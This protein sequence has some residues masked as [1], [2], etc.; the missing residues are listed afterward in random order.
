[1]SETRQVGPLSFIIW[2]IQER[3]LSSH[4]CNRSLIFSLFP[5]SNRGS[6]RWSIIVVNRSGNISLQITNKKSIKQSRKRNLFFLHNCIFFVPILHWVV[7]SLFRSNIFFSRRLHLGLDGLP[8][9]QQPTVLPDSLWGLLRLHH[10]RRGGG[11]GGDGG[12]DDARGAG[13]P[14]C[15]NAEWGIFSLDYIAA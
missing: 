3:S 6:E 1:M 13:V 12:R 14:G 7:I 4:I 5:L 10:G 9:R 2:E 15:H 11:R 8:P